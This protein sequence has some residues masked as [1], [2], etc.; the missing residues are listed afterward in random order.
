MDQKKGNYLIN[1]K[2]FRGQ[3]IKEGQICHFL[4]SMRSQIILFF[5]QKRLGLTILILQTELN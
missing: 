4:A 3:L 1:S 5:N 2:K